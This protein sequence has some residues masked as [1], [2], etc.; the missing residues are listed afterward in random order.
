MKV[1]ILTSSPLHKMHIV[2]LYVNEIMSSFDTE[3][4][5]V[6]P[7]FLCKG[8]TDFPEVPCISSLEKLGK[9]L[10]EICAKQQVVVITNIL[11][12]D[13]HT[14]YRE[15]KK[16]KIPV[17]SIDKES[18]IF[19]M[20]DNYGK[21]HPDRVTK[22]DRRKFKIKAIPGLCQIYSYLEYQHVKFD[23]ILG[24]YNY[25]PD[26]CKHFVHIHSIKYDEYLRSVDRK[27]VV[28]G[29]YILFMD[30]GLAHLPSH[31][32]KVDAIDKQEYLDAMNAFFERV[33][34][35]FSMP[36]IVSAHPKSGYREN[37]FNGRP[38][39]LYKTPELL[40]Y[41][42]FVLAH[43]STSL[44]ELVL[45]KKKV[46]FMYSEDYMNSDSRTV[47]ENASEYADMLNAAFVDIKKDEKI[48]VRYDEEAYDD[49]IQKYLVCSEQ[50]DH[51][52]GE[53]IVDF[54]QSLKKNVFAEL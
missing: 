36:V 48:E 12:F 2:D 49:F 13:L 38:I 40:K 3:I 14:V 50:I 21:K 54:L 52:N 20:K 8:K 10:D 33:E 41:S 37:D 39:I 44:I 31:E 6:S 17:I 34:E 16:R 51:S 19:W 1:L 23:Y 27:P 35:Q 29:K 5:D 15:L 25:Y 11:I 47:L 4:W 28:D 18:M 32:G 24:A 45:Q 7:I 53:L 22:A 42:E 30:A 46:V 43:Y 9:E 26:A